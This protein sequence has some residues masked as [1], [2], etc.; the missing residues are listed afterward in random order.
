MKCDKCGMSMDKCKCNK[1]DSAKAIDIM[2]S[3]SVKALVKELET[4]KER[5]K[6]LEAL[7]I[8]NGPA[9]SAIKAADN[10]HMDND[11]VLLDDAAREKFYDEQAHDTTLNWPSRQAAAQKAQELSLKR[12]IAKGP[13]PLKQ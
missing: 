8:S 12:T 9:K 6:T 3:P 13:Q 1:S 11:S 2:E 10:P 4:V 5:V 7:P